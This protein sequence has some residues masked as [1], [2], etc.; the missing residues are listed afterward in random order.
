MFPIRTL[1]KLCNRNTSALS[2][3]NLP[4]AEK[5]IPNIEVLKV[6]FK[7]LIK[8][9]GATFPAIWKNILEHSH[10]T[11]ETL[12]TATWDICEEFLLL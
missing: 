6:L 3:Q 4:L 10:K 11:S 1:L 5:R 8:L 2:F 7:E 12:L 9:D